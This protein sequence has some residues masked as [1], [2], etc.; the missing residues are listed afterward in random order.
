[1]K[2]IGILPLFL[3]AAVFSQTSFISTAGAQ[4]SPE[5]NLVDLH[6]NALGGAAALQ[7]VTSLKWTGS[8]E[9]MGNTI[10][11]TQYQ[12]KNGKIR[13]EMDMGDMGEMVMAFDGESA[14]STNPMQGG[15]PQK[16]PAEQTSSIEDQATI[17]SLLYGY[18]ENG[19]TLELL[20][21]E[22]VRGA[23]AHKL[24]IT[25]KDGTEMFVFVDV[26]TNLLVKQEFSGPGF[27]GGSMS[28]EI[29]FSDYRETGGVKL[30]FS[31]ETE[32]NSGE[33]SFIVQY[34]EVE[35]NPDLDDNLFSFPAN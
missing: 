7:A 27:Q 35:V 34:S 1:M 14:W 22:T 9:M 11:Y 25:R 2:S 10:L 4:N 16:M 18:E 8:S 28:S 19:L 17:G 23:P 12:K 32:I 15:G 30:A 26:E 29:Y 31:R 13:I 24:K 6:L 5:A 3:F 21:D 33:F 20:E